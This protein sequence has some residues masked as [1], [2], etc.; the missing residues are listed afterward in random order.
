ME[1]QQQQSEIDVRFRELLEASPMPKAV[2]RLIERTSC[3]NSALEAPS[4]DDA[5][6]EAATDNE[7]S[8]RQQRA[9]AREDKQAAAEMSGDMEMHATTRAED[10]IEG[11]DDDS[12]D[13]IEHHEN[14][15]RED[16][17]D[18]REASTPH[19]RKSARKSG[20]RDYWVLGSTPRAPVYQ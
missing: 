9:P 11:D 8:T 7:L 18:E 6:L 1:A 17:H 3:Q 2:L 12:R 14:V 20:P 16:D 19:R 13:C 15:D 5:Q 10:I 4:V